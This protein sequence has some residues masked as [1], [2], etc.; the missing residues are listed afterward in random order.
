MDLSRDG[1]VPINA[2]V[3]VYLFI[4]SFV[5]F[6]QYVQGGYVYITID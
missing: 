5:G 2:T 4:V 1:I 3:P 6:S